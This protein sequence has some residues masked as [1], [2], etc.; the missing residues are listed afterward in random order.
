MCYISHNLYEDKFGTVPPSG[1][2]RE[3]GGNPQ[4]P[5]FEK[6]VH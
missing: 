6:S 2:S 5:I 1:L 4:S 3:T